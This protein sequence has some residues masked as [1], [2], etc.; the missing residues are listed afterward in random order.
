MIQPILI[1][2]FTGGIFSEKFDD[3]R[4]IALAPNSHKFVFNFGV[5]ELLGE[6]ELV[7]VL[8]IADALTPIKYACN[9]S[10]YYYFQ[11]IDPDD[12]VIEVIGA[13]TPEDGEFCK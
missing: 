4:N 7:R 11:L 13:Y 10:L 8:N 2:W 1:K 9:V 3:L 5:E 12:N 6:Y